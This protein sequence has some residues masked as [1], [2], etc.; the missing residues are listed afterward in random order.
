MQSEFL[1]Y[2]RGTLAAVVGLVVASLILAYVG[3]QKEPTQLGGVLIVLLAAVAL[4]L[5]IYAVTER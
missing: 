2:D 4:W 1:A 5:W 3:R